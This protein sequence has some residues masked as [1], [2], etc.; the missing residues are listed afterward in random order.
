MNILN[1]FYCPAV[2]SDEHVFSESGI[3]HQMTADTTH[4]VRTYMYMSC[5]FYVDLSC[6]CMPG[7]GFHDFVL[8][9]Y[10]VF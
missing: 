6:F 4:K 7:F 1:D 9:G 8:L 5:T 10:W 3:Y 2:L